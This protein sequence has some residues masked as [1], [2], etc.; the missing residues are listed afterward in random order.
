MRSRFVTLLLDK[1][2]ELNRDFGALNIDLHA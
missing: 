2:A 1:A